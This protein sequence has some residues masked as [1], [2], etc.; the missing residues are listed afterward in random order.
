MNNVSLAETVT[1]RKKVHICVKKLY[2]VSYYVYNI[3]FLKK[4]CHE[5]TL[6]TCVLHT[7]GSTRGS[8]SQSQTSATQANRNTKC[9]RFLTPH[10]ATP[11]SSKSMG[12][13]LTFYYT[14]VIHTFGSGRVQTTMCPVWYAWCCSSH[15]FTP[16]SIRQLHLEG[17]WSSLPAP[18]L[19]PQI[20]SRSCFLSTDSFVFGGVAGILPW[21]FWWCAIPVFIC[22]RLVLVTVDTASKWICTRVCVTDCWYVTCCTCLCLYIWVCVS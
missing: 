6:L 4:V 22:V 8:L 7:V 2:L 10:S 20:L 3:D 5:F 11:R 18:M 13:V 16:D 12:K 9:P 1:A 21:S 17:M 14:L 19:V 15:L